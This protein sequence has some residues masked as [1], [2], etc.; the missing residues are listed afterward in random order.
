MLHLLASL[1]LMSPPNAITLQGALTTSGAVPV[2]GTYGLTVRLFAASEGGAPLLEK[3]YVAVAVVGGVFSITVEGVGPD[4][5]APAGER[6]VEVQV[7]ADPPLPRTRVASVPMALVASLAGGLSCSGCVGAAQLE[8]GVAAAVAKVANLAQ[9]AFTGQ[10]EDL[11]GTPKLAAV[12]LSG[13]YGDLDGTP[14][15]AAVALSG[16]YGDL[17]GGPDLAPYARLDMANTWQK[18]QT[19]GADLDVALHQALLFRFQNAA[20]EPAACTAERAGLAYFDTSKKQLFVCD[21]AAFVAFSKL[22]QLG[23]VGNPGASCEDIRASGG[24]V[25]NGVYWLKPGAKV[26]QAWCDMTT[27]GGGWTLALNLDTSD[28]HVMWWAHP[29][30]TSADTYGDPV[31]AFGSDL[32]G[33]AWNDMTGG[34]KLLLVVHKQG[35]IVGWKIFQRVLGKTLA[36]ALAGGDNT[37]LGGTVLGSDTA[38]VWTG[39]RL[40]RLSTALYANHCV[41][42]GGGCTSGTTGSPDGDRIGSHE[43]SP[44]DNDGGG[45]GNW[46]DM[47]YCCTGQTYAGFGCNGSAFRTTSEAQAGWAYASQNGTFGSDSYG[48]MTGT[49]VDATGC[50][51]ANW[52][53][54]NGVDYDYALFIG[55]K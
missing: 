29:L 39:E 25:G 35:V 41:A 6:F 12:A 18:T 31:N 26:Y 40:V 27:A 2:D 17:D 23:T 50:D 47:H 38:N 54:A 37:P 13:K 46:H 9:I 4:L 52:A 53:K 14:K 55:G 5:F 11:F 49:Q 48:A 19:L 20:V 22:G 32:K 36:G 16:K 30:W 8:P 21:G 15:L 45:L 1:L 44:S 7:E 24:S 42:T 10:Y 51:K 28:G 34:D 33:A 3:V 43:A